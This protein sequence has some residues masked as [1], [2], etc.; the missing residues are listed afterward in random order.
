MMCVSDNLCAVAGERDVSLEEQDTLRQRL[1]RLTETLERQEADVKHRQVSF[2]LTDRL[3][4]LRQ[5]CIVHLHPWLV[6]YI[7]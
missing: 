6:N 4:R 2:Y 7:N 5:T 3:G 1:E